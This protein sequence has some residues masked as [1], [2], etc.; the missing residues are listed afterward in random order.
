MQS[1]E[2]WQLESPRDLPPTG[3]KPLEDV[4]WVMNHPAGER[5]EGLL[6]KHRVRYVVLYKE[7]PDR[8]T[9]DYWKAFAARPDL[10]HRLRERGR[11]YR[12]S[13]RAGVCGLR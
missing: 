2:R 6:E 8:L 4:M 5:T 9:R 7:M 12:H 10:P 11:P 3:P 13:S 1:F